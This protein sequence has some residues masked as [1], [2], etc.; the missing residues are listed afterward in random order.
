MK[1]SHQS[2]D[3]AVLV[4]DFFCERLLNQ[5]NVSPHT[6]T[7]YRDAFRLRNSSSDS[8]STPGS[9]VI[10]LVLSSRRFTSTSCV[11]ATEDTYCLAPK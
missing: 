2:P 5:Q 8:P 4:R 11:C 9:W 7:A 3:F 1:S 10:C 6:V